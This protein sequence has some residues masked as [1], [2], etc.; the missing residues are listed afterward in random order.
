MNPDLN[1]PDAEDDRFRFFYFGSTRAERRKSIIIGAITVVWPILANFIWM[2]PSAWVGSLLLYV[3]LTWKVGLKFTTA[4]LLFGTVL[5]FFD[6]GSIEPYFRLH[7]LPL[8]FLIISLEF[9]VLADWISRLNQRE[10]ARK[11][12]AESNSC[13]D[14]TPTAG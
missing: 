8:P 3:A 14:T 10:H 5:E 1:I 9:G 13:D 12:L 4:G 2:Y 11:I 6:I 7:G